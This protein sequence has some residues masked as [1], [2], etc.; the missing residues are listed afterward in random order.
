[1][2]NVGSYAGNGGLHEVEGHGDE[3]L[4]LSLGNLEFL[5]D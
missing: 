5:T 4:E 1:M 2:N 3:G